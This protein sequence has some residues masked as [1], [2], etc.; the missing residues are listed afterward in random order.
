MSKKMLSLFNDDHEK[1]REMCLH[2]RNGLRTG[3]ATERIR[4]YVD[5][6]SKNFLI[7]HIQKEEKFLTQQTKNTRIK[8]AMANHR[9][10]IRL[11]TCSCEDLKVL[12]LLEEELEVHINFEENIVYKE[13]EENSNSKKDNATFGTTKGFYC[14]WNDP[15]WEE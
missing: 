4:H 12:N 14:Q 1:L 15:F 9:R 13:I 7:P 10:I 11:L 8:R 2:I 5:W 6:A 3:V